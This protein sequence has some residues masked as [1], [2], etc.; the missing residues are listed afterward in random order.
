MNSN[1]TTAAGMSLA[2]A[3]AFT[4]VSLSTIQNEIRDGNIEARKC[5]RRVIIA[6]QELRAWIDRLPR[7]VAT[8]AERD[9]AGPAI[10]R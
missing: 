7:A 5:G 6:T 1:E 2:D 4:G 10:A 9:P 8:T 3:A